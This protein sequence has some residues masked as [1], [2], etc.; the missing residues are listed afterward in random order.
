MELQYEESIMGKQNVKR[1][2]ISMDDAGEF[3]SLIA[4]Q[5]KSVHAYR[6]FRRLRRFHQRFDCRFTLYLFDRAEYDELSQNRKAELKEC[7]EWLSYGYHGGENDLKF[8]D[9]QIQ[10]RHI[11]EFA[12]SVSDNTAKNALAPIVRLHRFA[13]NARMLAFMETQGVRIFLTADDGRVSYDLTENDVETLNKTGVLEKE[14]RKYW[15]TDVRLEGKGWLKKVLAARKNPSGNVVIFTHE[16]LLMSGKSI[17][18]WVRLY[19]VLWILQHGGK[20][21]FI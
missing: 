20:Y 18:L 17:I 2:H 11:R 4:R 16:P 9:F 15:K 12:L 7:G 21:I 13:G 1:C 19:I 6:Y 5:G 10:C 14:N 3:F 8:E